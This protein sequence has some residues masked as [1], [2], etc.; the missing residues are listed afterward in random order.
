MA[1]VLT[2][3]QTLHPRRPGQLLWCAEPGSDGLVLHSIW[4]YKRLLYSLSPLAVFDRRRLDAQPQLT[5]YK[6]SSAKHTQTE[7][8]K[9]IQAK[10]QCVTKVHGNPNFH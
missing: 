5:C 3:P 7:H 10:G 9:A 2:S 4:E 1:T 6:C 8:L